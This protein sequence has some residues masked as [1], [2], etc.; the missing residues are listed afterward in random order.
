MTASEKILPPQPS[1]SSEATLIREIGDRLDAAPI[2]LDLGP[3]LGE[4]P[5]ALSTGER[6]VVV[7]PHSAIDPLD[8]GEHARAFR[9]FVDAT[10]RA[11][12]E[13]V[14]LAIASAQDLDSLVDAV[15][16]AAQ[17]G[18]F[19]ISFAPNRVGTGFA[20]R[21][22]TRLLDLGFAL[23]VL[24]AA[25]WLMLLLAVAIRVD[26]KGPAFFRQVRVGQQQRE[27]TLWKF[28]TMAVG[29]TQAG[30]HEVATSA[31][32]GIGAFLRRTKLDELPQVINIL[33]GELSLVG[34][35]PCL[36][37]QR[38]LVEARARRG[39]YEVRPGITGLA[40]IFEVDM[41][42]PQRL[43]RWDQ[44]YV[45]LR[46]FTYDLRLF[47]MTLLGRG[48]GDRMVEPHSAPAADKHGQKS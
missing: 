4:L 21:V 17:P 48:Q 9:Q 11:A 15:E 12:P 29:T 1:G 46:S 39:V 44:R 2:T 23:G 7:L 45:A 38:E 3:L 13:N 37:V 14:G 28:R 22:L 33:R 47:V 8:E 18:A 19:R 40:Q 32:T 20:S 24:V 42:E 35:R 31:V 6:H 34:P 27:F 26:S 5:S 36:P 10:E 16:A 25:G 43:A 30:T 41:S